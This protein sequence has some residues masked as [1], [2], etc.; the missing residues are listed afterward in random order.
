MKEEKRIFVIQKIIDGQLEVQEGAT[1]LERSQRQIWRL[2]AK[3]RHHGIRGVVHGNKGK[4]S[5]RKIA[6]ELKNKIIKLVRKKYGGINDRH[7]QEILER[8]E[9]ITIGRENLRK[10]LRAAAIAPKRNRRGVKYRKKRERKATFGMML[11]I[12]GSTHDWLE[13]RGPRLTLI[14]AIDDATGKVWARFEQYETTWG[15]LELLREIILKEGIPLSLY[16]DRHMIFFSP[17]EATLE[18]QLKNKKPMTQFGQAMDALNIK[19]IPAYSAPAKGRIE[20][21]WATLQ[22]RLVVELRLRKVSTQFQANAVLGELLDAHNQ[23]FMVAA[24]EACSTFRTPLPQAALD[25]I[26]CLKQTRVVAKD[27]T[28]SFE[29]LILQIPACNRFRSL[30]KRTV[31]VLQLRDGSIEIRFQNYIVATFSP[32]TVTRLTNQHIFG[33]SNLKKA[34]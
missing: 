9:K 24:K 5:P 21:L 18:E 6:D 20:R 2:L 22:D 27:H 26:L 29:G 30:V 10:I 3:M 14:G 31:E 19:L 28:V 7:L 8:Q 16:S 33:A 34:A 23:R 15:Y 11:Q 25:R 17:R 1:V 32:Q 13:D 12:D 4:V